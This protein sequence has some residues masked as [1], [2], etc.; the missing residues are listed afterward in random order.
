M[1]EKI[2]RKIITSITKNTHLEKCTRQSCPAFTHLS[3]G[4]A[5]PIFMVAPPQYFPSYFL[6]AFLKDCCPSLFLVATFLHLDPSAPS[7]KAASSSS[8]SSQ[9]HWKY[10]NVLFS[11]FF[12]STTLYFLAFSLT[13]SSASLLAF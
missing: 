13:F 6:L 7:K 8:I 11:F 12:F 4:L 3:Q 1:K 5:P 9:S 2:I 10:S